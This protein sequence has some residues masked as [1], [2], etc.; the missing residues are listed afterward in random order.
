MLAVFLTMT[1]SAFPRDVRMD[2][3]PPPFSAD[4]AVELVKKKFKTG[5]GMFLIVVVWSPLTCLQDQHH[6][7]YCYYAEPVTHRMLNLGVAG[8]PGEW[9]W[10]VTFAKSPAKKHGRGTSDFQT[11]QVR[12]NGEVNAIGADT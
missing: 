8:K 3:P 10:Y 11:Y 9:S 4:K 6:R 1:A 12:S 5:D 2:V 7:S